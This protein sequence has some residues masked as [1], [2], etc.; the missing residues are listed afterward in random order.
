M[1]FSRK[2]VFVFAIISGV[3]ACKSSSEPPRLT[4][5]ATL[6]VATQPPPTA[7]VGTSVQPVPV[8]VVKDSN[9]RPLPNVL[10]SFFGNNGATVTP[11]SVSTDADGRAAPASWIV[12]QHP[13]VAALSASA[14]NGTLSAAVV[15]NALVGP[16]VFVTLPANQVIGLTDTL[17][18]TATVSDAF[19]NPIQNANVSFQ[20]SNPTVATIS[21]NRLIAHTAGVTTIT[22]GISGSSITG[23]VPVTVASRFGHLGGRP[24]GVAFVPGTTNLFLVTSQ[25]VQTL[26]SVSGSTYAVAA[27]APVGFSPADVVANAQG[28]LAYVTSVDGQQVTIVNL[29]AMTV[30]A[31]ITDQT[32]TRVL[33]SPDGSL[34]YVAR[35][36]GVDVFSTSTKSLVASLAISSLV[37]GMALSADGSTLWVSTTFSG[38]LF[39]VNT[40]TM[41]VTASV[42][43][44]GTPQEVVYHA[45]SGNV[46]V[47][48]ESGW[49]DVVNG[50]DLTRVT[51]FAS[52][53]G[54]FGM[55]LSADQSTLYVSGTTFG[56]V[57]V[58]DRAT[59]TLSRT[60]NV[61]GF[62][63][64]IALLPDGRMAVANEA[65]YVSLVQ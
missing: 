49:V 21:G 35:E 17:T 38:Q 36:G 18:L 55:R 33:L 26:T 28:T 64:R 8:F 62:P 39:R 43:L 12:P 6:S 52:L 59:G 27:T 31:T 24:F 53:P 30:A 23:S 14:V 4:G 48:N 9:Q 3:A 63:R 56:N 57:Y 50:T 5:A 58:V 13:G 44:G 19:H 7:T 2:W 37:N 51:R 29:P 15:I 45:G 34:L 11:L 16:A 65:A 22:A 60:I 46:Y 47:A 61:G 20:S 32:T 10:V 42:T 54:S 40:S 1:Q 25:D 41:T